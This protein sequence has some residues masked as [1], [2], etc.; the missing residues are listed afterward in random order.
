MICRSCRLS[1]IGACIGVGVV[2]VVD[3]VGVVVVSDV[4]LF[5]MVFWSPGSWRDFLSRG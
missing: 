2:S 1:L 3:F 4:V 5:V